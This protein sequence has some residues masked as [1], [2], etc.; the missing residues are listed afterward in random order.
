L[1]PAS[2]PPSS[3]YG[4]GRA[5][6]GDV[7]I[8]GARRD[9]GVFDQA[10]AVYVFRLDGTAWVEE[11]KLTASDAQ[12]SDHFGGGLA[13]SGDVIVVGAP[14]RNTVGSDSGA[15]YVFRFTEGSWVEEAVLAPPDLWAYDQFGSTVSVYGDVLIA[16]SPLDDD[17][18]SG[19]GSA[20]VYRYSGGTWAQ[21]AK[22]TASDAD[23]G[24]DFGY[25][26]A[27]DG[28]VAVIGADRDDDACPGDPECYS[29]SAYVFRYSGGAW[30]EEAKLTASDAAQDDWF[31]V[32][33]AVDGDVIFVGAPFKDGAAGSEGAA[34]VFRRVGGTWTEEVKL[35]ASDA[36]YNDRFGSVGVEGDVA[37][38]GAGN[39]DAAASNSGAGYVF[40]RVGGVWTEEAKL[41]A[42]N[43]EVNAYLGGGPVDG[44]RALMG[45]RGADPSGRAYAFA[46]FGDCNSNG[47]LDLCETAGGTAQ[48]CQPNQIPDACEPDCNS[49]GLPDECEAAIAEQDCDGDGFCNGVEIADCTPGDPLCDDCNTNGLP[50]ECDPDCN[51][52]FIA[53]DCDIRDETSLDCQPNQIP[54]DCEPDCGTNGVPDDCETDPA[55]QDCDGDGVCN[56]VAI[57]NC[58][59]EEPACGDCNTNGLPDGC[60][61]D[62]NSNQVADDCDIRDGT[63]PDV[64]TDG[65]PDE[66][67]W[68]ELCN[69]PIGLPEPIPCATN[70]DCAGF[71][72]ATCTGG[73][74][75]YPTPTPCT[76]N[77]DC[78]GLG[79]GKCLY[80]L[81][82]CEDQDYHACRD[83]TW[84]NEGEWDLPTNGCGFPEDSYNGGC[85]ALG[86][87]AFSIVSCGE[88]I[89]GTSMLT[90]Y[91]GSTR[92]DTDWYE[93]IITEPTRVTIHGTAEFDFVLGLGHNHG[94]DSCDNFDYYFWAGHYIVEDSCVK[95]T[96]S[97]CVH[98]G[99]WWIA[100]VPQWAATSPCL[101]YEFVVECEAPCHVAC[102]TGY[103]QCEE[104][105][106]DT[107]EFIYGGVVKGDDCASTD[108]SSGCDVAA[109]QP[110]N[111]VLNPL[112]N[113]GNSDSA[114]PAMNCATGESVG[115]KWFWFQAQSDSV[116]ISTCSSLPELGG[117]SVF[118][119]YEGDCL[120]TLT[121]IDCSED[122]DCDP[123]SW[124]GIT[125]TTGLTVGDTYYL[126]FASWDA[127]SQGTYVLQIEC[128]C[129]D[130]APGAC[131]L[132]DGSCV[133]ATF[134]Q[135]E[136]V[137]GEYQGP[138]TACAG[139]LDSNGI[140]DLCEPGA[141]CTGG[142]D[143]AEM[144]EGACTLA[145][146]LEWVAGATCNPNPCQGAC[147]RETGFPPQWECTDIAGGACLGTW[148]EGEECSAFDCAVC[149]A[150]DV[151]SYKTHGTAGELYLDMG[152]GAG[153]EPRSGGLTKLEIDVL[154]AASF[155][156]GVVVT[157]VGAG[158]VSS[159]VSG[160]SVAGDT[161]TV[162]FDPALPDQDACVIDLDCGGTACVRSCEGDLNRSGNTTAADSLQTKIRFGET[163]TSANCE[164]DFDLS[165]GISA[166]DALQIKI[167]F[168]FTAPAC[169]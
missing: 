36:A 168:G 59:P 14:D 110:C 33:V 22:L 140:D 106:E 139:D 133:T 150:L 53:D 49:D 67:Q 38:I 96:A 26:V 40:R 51:T 151:R 137:S 149:I 79:T 72:P 65:V 132:S 58:P 56:A 54:D 124:Q 97:A 143:C 90:V 167:R 57:A 3:S 11:A 1:V 69:P 87:P 23:E 115:V 102:C 8:I 88:K 120:N 82:I 28:D 64:N 18:G 126:Q 86:G 119:L 74:C 45:A 135:C 118:A 43:P 37:L 127:A 13:V 2:V 144:T 71:G 146:G 62:C 147:C 83:G 153:I 105:D 109:E 125:C 155:A 112:D 148:F 121:E 95:G 47:I 165:G 32:S 17:D 158:D 78:V 85:S 80:S 161:V 156:N 27:L 76:T 34:Y 61:T 39:A 20:Y 19:S 7:A 100:A 68:D 21:E 41:T 9:D 24:D 138:G 35:T 111:S 30:T 55:L 130:Y 101:D 89:C 128:P 116:Q 123:S 52:N 75:D 162:T 84:T 98:P 104:T 131:C 129:P 169:P 5:L 164:W 142:T 103:D 15:V 108:C 157:C 145:G 163:A 122:R 94:D 50:D 12:P 63:S 166:S 117:D 113:T 48:D 29:G 136:N 99:T 6:S 42:S 44:G 25:R 141:C 91:A 73:F 134:S 77:S 160:T 114:L 81:G 92:R 31:G 10:G 46:G 66:C 70:G 152:V 159:S 4:A 154:D 93:L 60:E 107:C 16:G